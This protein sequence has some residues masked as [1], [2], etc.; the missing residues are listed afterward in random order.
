MTMLV[1]MMCSRVG[2]QTLVNAK[3]GYN[4]DHW[5][6]SL[7]ANNLFDEKYNQYVNNRTN[8]AIIGAPRSVGLILDAG[9]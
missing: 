1:R 7:F 5:S 4:A 9:F 3:I 8:F 2:A 6:M